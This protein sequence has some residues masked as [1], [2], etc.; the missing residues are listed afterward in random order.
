MNFIQQIAAFTIIAF[1]Q[2]SIKNPASIA[3]EVA[4]ITAIRDYSN[5][6]LA[7]L[8]PTTPQA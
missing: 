5:Q 2:A 6:A 8:P 3:K 4:I 7:T 1:L